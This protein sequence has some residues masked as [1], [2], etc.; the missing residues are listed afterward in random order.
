MAYLAGVRATPNRVVAVKVADEDATEMR[1]RVDEALPEIRIES[2][3]GRTV[4]GD[5]EQ[6]ALGRRGGDNQSFE[7]QRGVEYCVNDSE[8][9]VFANEDGYASSST[10]KTVP[11]NHDKVRKGGILERV[12]FREGL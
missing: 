3:G 6:I 10:F 9:E 7:V 4:D 11:S 8:R 2:S 1:K 12:W 5:Y